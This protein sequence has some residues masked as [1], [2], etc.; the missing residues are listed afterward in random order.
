MRP[1]MGGPGGVFLI[2]GLIWI[3][4]VSVLLMALWR[5]MRA[6]EKMAEHLAGIEQALRGRSL[7]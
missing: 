3:V 4:V 1:M 6:Q 2:Y 5:G 7:S